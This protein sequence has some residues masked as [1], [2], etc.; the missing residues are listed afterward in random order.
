MATT[1][2]VR[3]F[4]VLFATLSLCVFGASRSLAKSAVTT[5]NEIQHVVLAQIDDANTAFKG[6]DIV[7]AKEILSDAY[8]E[9]FEALGMEMVVK[10]YI[11][12]A[13]AYQLERMFGKIRKGMTAN[14]R[15]AVDQAINNLA[16]ALKKDA[17]TLDLKNIQVEGAG[18]AIPAKVQASPAQAQ[19]VKAVKGEATGVFAPESVAVEIEQHL[20]KAL[21][22]YRNGDSRRAK[23]LVSD[24]YF[25]LFEGE[26]LE[27]AIAIQS[28]SLK[29][30]IESKFGN[31]QGLMEKAASDERVERAV[32][33]LSSQI[34][35]VA[36]K[37]AGATG[38]FPLFM[39]SFF[40]IAREGFEA[41]LILSALITYLRRTENNEKVKIVGMG[42]FI[43][44]LL[45]IVTAVVFMEVYTQSAASREIL[46]GIT[47]L[48]A[49]G[50][51]FYVS[52]WLTSK[53]E[54]AKWMSYIQKQ[55]SESIGKGSMLTL[56]FA[57]FIVVY[58]EG[59]ETILFYS[60]LLANSG[61]GSGAP[62]WSGFFAGAA[63]LVAVYYTFKYGAAKIPI[64]PFFNATSIF[65]FYMAFVFA[66][67]GV[68][69]LQI[70]GL[71]KSTPLDWA[72]RIGFLGI[73]P[74][75]E[76][77]SIQMMLVMAAL[78]ALGYLYV[79]QPFKARGKVL[80]EVAH[81]LGDLQKLHN[82]VGHI[83]THV[84]NGMTLTASEVTKSQSE[85]DREILEHLNEIDG[86]SDELIDHLN[87]LQG[88]LAL[89][90]GNLGNQK[91]KK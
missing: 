41:I 10:K 60:A 1:S 16:E 46:E 51:L 29:T 45:S 6:G 59:A 58:R 91:G 25:D 13:Q 72:P 48:I 4:F 36:G 82:G 90:L 49:A 42:A 86:Y 53:A 5:W 12:S 27:A 34:I 68:I 31:I 26:G 87:G 23:G 57:A 66:G 78:V 14:D 63:A 19:D 70:G 3:V 88:G 64:R 84:N 69:E 55:V 37:L 85:K 8:F 28:S 62:I 77:L 40:I 22:L 24:T 50:V 71:I 47:M 54:A 11:S 79:L 73:H 56:G 80:Q 18:Y 9:K 76:S 65:L 61:A 15:E 39:A 81:I 17:A 30:E 32:R 52:Y 75:L 2:R 21:G 43:A 44:I 89:I 7:T 67:N 74:T 35:E 38:W 33:E 83:R 20:K